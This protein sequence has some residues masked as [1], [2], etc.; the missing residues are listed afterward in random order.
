MMLTEEGERC[1]LYVLVGT[2]SFDIQ[3]ELAQLRKSLETAA[4]EREDM[5]KTIAINNE[6]ASDKILMLERKVE[7]V[8]KEIQQHLT[9]INN[10]KQQLRKKKMKPSFLS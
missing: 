2:S 4:V 6:R 9:T 1:D 10:L 3:L 5:K 7:S 8:E